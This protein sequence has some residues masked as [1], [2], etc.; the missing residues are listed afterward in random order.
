MANVQSNWQQ[1]DLTFEDCQIRE[2]YARFGLAIYLGQC[3]ERTLGLMLATM[4]GAENVATRR[5]FRNALDREFRKTLGQMA[6]DLGDSEDLPKAFEGRLRHAIKE[7]NRLA[8]PYFWDSAV[9]FCNAAGREQMLSDLQETV[10]FLC[11]FHD[12][13]NGIHE[14]WLDSVGISAETVQEA[15]AKMAGSD[16]AT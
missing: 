16:W 8:H 13:L 2:V 4:Y 10:D 7:R 6:K 12:E 1:Q 9:E 15:A 3:V 11:G 14:A 5:D